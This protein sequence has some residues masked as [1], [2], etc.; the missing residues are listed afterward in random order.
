MENF[1]ETRR[2][3]RIDAAVLS[4]C[5]SVWAI[6]ARSHATDSS[7]ARQARI[8]ASNAIKLCRTYLLCGYEAPS[9]TQGLLEENWVFFP[10]QESLKKW[11]KNASQEVWPFDP[12]Q[13]PSIG[14]L[15]VTS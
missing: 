8:E 3:A 14:Q 11:P 9:L 15:H 4:T 1:H 7:V 13:M 10:L 12:W 5:Q 6:H 2:L